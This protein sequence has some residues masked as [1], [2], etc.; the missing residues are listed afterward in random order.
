MVYDS[1]PRMVVIPYGKP[2]EFS[3]EPYC[4]PAEYRAFQSLERSGRV[5]IFRIAICENG[6]CKKQIPKGKEYCS[7][8]CY[9]EVFMRR[10]WNMRLKEEHKK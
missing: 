3:D 10:N 8:K 4:S 7:F 6:D 2:I 5:S 9:A 1:E